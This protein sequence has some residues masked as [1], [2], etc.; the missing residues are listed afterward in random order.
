MSKNWPKLEIKKK[1][2][3]KIIFFF[4]Q[5]PL[6]IFLKKLSSFGQFFDIQMAI[7]RRASPSIG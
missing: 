4:K 1:K 3:P 2:L 5:F 6:A 7:F